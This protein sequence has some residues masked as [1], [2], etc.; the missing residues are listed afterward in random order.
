MSFRRN[1]QRRRGEFDHVSAQ[2]NVPSGRVYFSRKGSTDR[3]IRSKSV[4]S[5]TARRAAHLEG[6]WQ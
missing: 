1:H 5:N 3:S 4:R 2:I 6:R